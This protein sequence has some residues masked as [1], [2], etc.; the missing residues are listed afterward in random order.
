MLKL[1]VFFWAVATVAKLHGL[2]LLGPITTKRAYHETVQQ[3]ETVVMAL[4]AIS[5]LGLIEIDR[6]QLD[7][8]VLMV[9]YSVGLA[10]LAEMHQKA[11]MRNHSSYIILLGACMVSFWGQNWPSYH[12]GSLISCRQQPQGVWLKI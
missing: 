12:Y 7:T 6:L 2:L 1:L 4:S 8:S 10:A 3:S 11:C 5:V 9:S